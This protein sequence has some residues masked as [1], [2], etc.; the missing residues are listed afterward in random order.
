MATK[1]KTRNEKTNGS[2]HHDGGLPAVRELDYRTIAHVPLDALDGIQGRTPLLGALHMA[3]LTTV[4]DLIYAGVLRDGFPDRQAMLDRLA[5]SG[6]SPLQAVDVVG[7]I[8]RYALTHAHPTPLQ[9]K[10]AT[11][12]H[13]DAPPTI[14][15]PV[16]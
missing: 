8:D 2:S 12:P 3:S 9:A 13:L 1:S 10:T 15:T 16:S 5:V 11:R 14:L 6:L 7:A 4:R